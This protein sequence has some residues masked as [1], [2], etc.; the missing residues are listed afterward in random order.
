MEKTNGGTS[1]FKTMIRNTFGEVPLL[2]WLLGCL[3]AVILEQL[4]GY[5]L[6]DILGLSKVPVLFGLDRKS[7]CRERV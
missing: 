5:E 6:T 3:V 7:S 1:R 2:S 4:V